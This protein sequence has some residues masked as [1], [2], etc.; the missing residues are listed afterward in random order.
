MDTKQV[1]RQEVE[2]EEEEGGGHGGGGIVRWFR[3]LMF[4]AKFSRSKQ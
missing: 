3:I 1:G 2:E 4:L